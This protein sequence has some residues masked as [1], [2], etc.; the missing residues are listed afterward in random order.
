[1]GET[2]RNAKLAYKTHGTLSEAKDNAILFPHMYSGTPRG[3]ETRFVGEGRPLDPTRYFIVLPGQFG[4]GFSSCPSKTPPTQGQGAFPNVMIGDD[5]RA[6]HRLVNEQF[7]IGE[8]HLVLGWSMCAEQTYEWAV[9]YPDMV[10]RAAPFAGT[11]N[12]TPHDFIFVCLHEDVI[13]SDPAWNNG[14]YTEPH[15]VHVGLRP[16]AQVWSVIGVTQQLYKQ[17]AS[18][19]AGFSSLDDLNRNFK[20]AWFLPMDPNNLLC[21][22]WKWRHG[23]VSLH[24][25]GD[26]AAALGRIKAKTL[27]MPFSGDMFF[28]VQDHV[29]EQA[30]IPNSERR[31]IESHWGHF[32]MFCMTEEDRRAIDDN[33]RRPAGH[34]GLGPSRRPTRVAMPG[35]PIDSCS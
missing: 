26:L 33:L 9:R 13:K 7:G 29:D 34:T 27:L 25:G 23:D 32:A 21:M 28:P 22:A 16:H 15:A 2:L 12:T 35:G 18:H 30:L 1:M 19:D 8:L 24:A 11:A 5:V 4:N 6:Q 20:E 14:F 17:E 10:K 3:M 31:V